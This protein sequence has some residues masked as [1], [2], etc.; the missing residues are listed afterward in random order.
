MRKIY[1]FAIAV[2]AVM[3]SCS[4][5]DVISGSGTKPSTNVPIEFNVQKQN[6]TRAASNLEN[7][8]HYN[9]GVWAWKTGGANGATTLADVEV[10]NHYLVGY[11][12]DAVG[13]D[14]STASTWAT[15]PGST[16]DHTSP[17]FYEGLGKSEYKYDGGTDFKGLYRISDEGTGANLYHY[18]D[19]MSV[20]ANQWLRYWDLAYTNTKFYCYAPYNKDVTFDYSTQTMTFPLT[21][22]IRDG[23]DNPQNSGYNAHSR[24]LGEFMYAGV[25]ATNSALADV[26]V[27]FK[28]MGAQLFIRFYEDIAGYKVE[29]IDLGADR[30]E[31]TTLT[32]AMS[33]IQA[34]PSV[35]NSADGT[36]SK[37]WYY[38]TQ[39]ASVVYDNDVVPTYTPAWK[40]G[41][42]AAATT[43]QTPLM[44]KI[45]TYGF[46]STATSTPAAN[47][48]PYAG[49]ASTTHYVIAEKVTTGDQTYSYSPTIYY[50]VAQ[51]QEGDE[52]YTA[53]GFTFH[54]S[55]RII[56]EDNKEVITVHNATVHVPVSGTATEKGTSATYPITAWK[57]NVKYTYT[58]KFTKNSTGTTNPTTNIDPT[59]PT[60]ST[61][62][63]LYPIVFDAATIDDF[64]TNFSEHIV[65]EGTNY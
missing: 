46:T 26:T 47:L 17:W 28:H 33:G 56:A 39:G 30:G 3:T 65:S 55:Y 54:I 8:N 42:D 11:G 21:G 53:T 31:T 41:T 37:G 16:G 27:P 48:S 59:D 9:F 38:T 58:F 4:S 19:Y 2:A 57:P 1:L 18:A 10:M 64:T 32:D 7:V 49:L 63:S 5:D 34:A 24:T 6:I 23:Y 52:S 13:Y 25:K 20:N 35:Y 45:P 50:P 44:F 61:T 22:T 51:P 60:P 29:I 43:V 14:H 36:Y 12:G 15:V 40:K 62:K